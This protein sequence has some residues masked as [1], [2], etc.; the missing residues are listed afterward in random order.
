ML[1]KDHPGFFNSE[2]FQV[3]GQQIMLNFE[4]GIPNW[5]L[6]SVESE[7]LL[8]LLRKLNLLSGFKKEVNL[9]ILDSGWPNAQVASDSLDAMVQIMNEVRAKLKL[10][11]AVAY[12]SRHF[13][14][15]VNTHCIDILDSLASFT[16]TPIGEGVRLV[17]LPLCKGQQSEQ[18]LEDLLTT[19]WLIDLMRGPGLLGS[20]MPLNQDRKEL[21]KK[22]RNIVMRM[23]RPSAGAELS[24]DKAILEALFTVINEYASLT[25]SLNLVNESWTVRSN[26]LK[27]RW[28]ED[29]SLFVVAAAGNE[30]VDIFRFKKSF[31]QLC[32]NRKD[33]LAVMNMD[34]QGTI[35]S[36]SFVSPDLLASVNVVGFNGRIDSQRCGTSFAAPRVAWLLA[37]Y[38]LLDPKLANPR[39]LGVRLAEDLHSIR[40]GKGEDS[41]DSIR[42]EPTRLFERFH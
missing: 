22:A 16:A 26:V 38:C 39:L 23:K 9:F 15:P 35:C 8:T 31:A 19:A 20:E 36:S 5:C 30:N 6:D 29:F 1:D 13:T 3:T 4:S 32:L 14:K 33:V 12:T 42:L 18:L 21:R 17:Y 7:T 25:S 28:P 2:D 40:P 41:L 34:S 37:V 10:G 24:T 11:D 27:F